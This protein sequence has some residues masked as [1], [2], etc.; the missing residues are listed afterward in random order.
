[1]EQQFDSLGEVVQ[2][3]SL[4]DDEPAGIE[5]G[6]MHVASSLAAQSG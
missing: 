6:R 2:A 4:E 1:M 3:I 5:T